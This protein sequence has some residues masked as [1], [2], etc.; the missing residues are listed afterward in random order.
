[1]SLEVTVQYG[2]RK[3]W[4]PPRYLVALWAYGALGRRGERC[5]L[6][7]RI[8]G[9]AESRRLNRRYRKK[10]RPTNVLAF[11]GEQV[12]AGGAARRRLLGDLVVCAPVVEREAREQGKARQAHWAHMIVHGA[13]HLLG[14]DHEEAAEQREMRA[15]EEETLAAVGLTR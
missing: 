3:P 9:S 1:M 13:L 5:D 7:V 2:T 4:A 11:P 6:S 10:D 8:V 15:R 12:G 14:Y